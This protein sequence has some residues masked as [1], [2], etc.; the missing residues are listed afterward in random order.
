MILSHNE[1]TDLAGI[2]YSFF[3]L[4]SISGADEERLKAKATAEI[5]SASSYGS[6]C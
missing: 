6:R 1:A 3:Y 2:N 4:T 5:Q